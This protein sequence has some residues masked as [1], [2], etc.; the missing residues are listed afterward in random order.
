M[1]DS[2]FGINVSLGA[3]VLGV[4]VSNGIDHGVGGGGSVVGQDYAGH[5][6]AGAIEARGYDGENNG[7]CCTTFVLW[8]ACT[9]EQR[10]ALVMVLMREPWLVGRE[11]STL[12]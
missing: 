5:V 3:G 7:Y 1:V 12:Y 9:I 8:L 2:W 10:V 6:R 11:R 4:N